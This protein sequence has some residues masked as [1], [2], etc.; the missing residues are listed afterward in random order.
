MTKSSLE[1]VAPATRPRPRRRLVRRS[2]LVGG[3]LLLLVLGLVVCVA[4]VMARPV[5]DEVRA[6]ATDGGVTYLVIGNGSREH[7]PQG[8]RSFGDKTKFA[9]SRADVVLLVHRSADGSTHTVSVP[10]DIVVQRSDGSPTRLALTL[11]DGVQQT[12]DA[13]CRTLK[14]GVNHVVMIDGAGVTD[15]VNAMGGVTVT[16]D[17]PVRDAQAALSL[18]AGTQRLDGTQA[19]A[20]VRSRHPEQN[21]GGTWRTTDEATGAAWRA[22]WSATVFTAL[23]D[24]LASA[25]PVTLA[26]VAW[27]VSGELTVDSGMG[28]LDFLDLARAASS[29]KTLPI[30]TMGGLAVAANAGTRSALAAADLGKG[31]RVAA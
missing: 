26:H 10:R 5:R 17:H 28:P 13:L 11:L 21:V 16:L 18:P 20:L 31:C 27:T 3:I 24:Q 14:V 30:R 29:P 1:S 9:G 7:T 22:S 6:T 12:V 19:L 23:Q 8:V 4:V 2:V 25:G 15:T